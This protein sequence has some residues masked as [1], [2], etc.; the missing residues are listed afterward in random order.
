MIP[1]EA[2]NAFATGRNPENAAVGA[3]T[4]LA[5]FAQMAMLFGM[6]RMPCKDAQM[7]R[8]GMYK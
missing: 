4:A 3:I 2:P 8:T 7:C 1:N 6:S 5:N